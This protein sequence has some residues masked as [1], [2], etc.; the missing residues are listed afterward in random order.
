MLIS[1]ILQYVLFSRPCENSEWM[2]DY[3]MNK[4]CPTCFNDRLKPFR[5]WHYGKLFGCVDLSHPNFLRKEIK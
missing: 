5:F 3:S 4:K 1:S 2:I